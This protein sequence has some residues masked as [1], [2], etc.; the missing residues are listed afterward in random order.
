MFFSPTYCR[1]C[2]MFRPVHKPSSGTFS[3]YSCDVV[4]QRTP[5]T[6]RSFSRLCQDAK[7]PNRPWDHRASYAVGNTKRPRREANHWPPPTARLRVSGGS[8]IPACHAQGQLYLYSSVQITCTGANKYVLYERQLLDVY[9]VRCAVFVQA[10]RWK[11]TAG[12]GGRW[13]DCASVIRRRRRRNRGRVPRCVSRQPTDTLH[14]MTVISTGN[15]T[16]V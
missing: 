15:R 13:S 14:G 7:R 3:K 6:F 16:W 10:F 4:S 12:S 9:T 11:C 8:Y 2:D 5:S 1:Q